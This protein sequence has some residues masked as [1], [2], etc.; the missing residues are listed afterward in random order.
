LRIDGWL[1]VAPPHDLHAADVFT[2]SASPD[3]WFGAA[4][5][6][7]AEFYQMMTKVA[8]FSGVP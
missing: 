3:G 5:Q 7:R 6:E 8:G 4:P 1:I 2:P